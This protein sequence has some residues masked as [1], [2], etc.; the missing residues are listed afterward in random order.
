L[1]LTRAALV[2]RLPWAIIMPPLP[3]L[4]PSRGYG[5]VNRRPRERRATQRMWSSLGEPSLQTRPG[6]ARLFL[7]SPRTGPPEPPRAVSLQSFTAPLHLASGPFLLYDGFMRL[8]RLP[9]SLGFTLSGGIAILFLALVAPQTAR[10]DSPGPPKRF[11]PAPDELG[12]V[13]RSVVALL[14]ERDTAKFAKE[15]TASAEDWKAIA[16][17]NLPDV[18]ETLQSFADGVARQLRE[19][20]TS[21]KAFLAKGDLLHLDFSKGDW[22][23]RVVDPPRV[24]RLGFGRT[25]YPSLQAE[26]ETMP[27]VQQVEIILNPDAGAAN[28]PKGEFKL[29]LRR[30]NKFPNGWRAAG[31]IQWESFPPG[32]ADEKTVREMA[33]LEKAANPGNTGLTDTDDPAL[34]QLGQTLVRFLRQRDTNIY[35]KEALVNSDLLWAQMQ[36]S[37]ESGPSRQEL[38]QELNR[39]TQEQTDIAQAMLTQADEAGIE[40]KNVELKIAEVS[41]GRLQ[42][43]GASG[44]L[45]G[46]MGEQFKLKLAVK[47]DGKSKTGVSISGEYVVAVN[48]V[49]RFADAWKV[50]G[51]IHWYRVPAGVLDEKATAAMELEDY[52]AEHRSLPPASAAPEIEFTTL[53]GEKKMK[54]SELRGKVVVLDFWATWCGPCQKPMADL[55]QLGKAHPDWADKVAIVPLSIDDTLDI[56]R[57]HVNKRGWT[58]TFNVWSGDGGW[59]S[60]PA[61]SFRV[62]GVPTTYIIDPSGKIVVAGHPAAM[63]LDETVDGALKAAR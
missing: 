50:Q 63:A 32:I 58:N 16:S 37:G 30:L 4:L 54:L 52:V 12:A 38:D 33:I 56:V 53:D 40:F 48:Q 61:R 29:L 27:S 15:I 59:Q 39:S 22:H 21:A 6:L 44:S 42:R 31:G 25:H 11:Q 36:K 23:A 13:N 57:R 20:E 7:L 26:G 62:S 8:R 49:L 1:P 51:G 17:T 19:N 2:P 47:A 18:G 35:A 14:Q 41:V 3:E 24:G 43:S 46:L 34:L 9:G 28:F 55:Q 5:E 45:E 10:A 60:A